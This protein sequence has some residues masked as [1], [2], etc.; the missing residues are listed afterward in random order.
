MKQLLTLLTALAMTS[1][2]FA[3]DN[4]SKDYLN[5]MFEEC[6]QFEARYIRTMTDMGNG[7][8]RAEVVDL[9]GAH[10]MAGA[11]LNTGED[12]LEHGK[13][14]FYYGN[15][16]VES[17]GYYEQGIKV[18]TWKRFTLLGEPRTDRYY[19]PESVGLLRSAM[20]GDAQMMRS[21]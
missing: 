8:H 15:G 13:F 20:D 14:T 17:Q 9:S 6:P 16:Q 2:V 3:Q 5:A 1:A 10:K 11:Y 19:N 21:R 4:I 18:G 7:L 12:M